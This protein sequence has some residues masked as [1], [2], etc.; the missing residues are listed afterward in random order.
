M[1][2]VAADRGADAVGEHHGFVAFGAE[3]LEYRRVGGTI[4]LG[5]DIGAYHG[6][7]TDLVVVATDDVLLG[8]HV[9]MREQLQH[10]G[11][12]GHGGGDLDR[13]RVGPYADEFLTWDAVVQERH[14]HV[15]HAGVAMANHQALIAGETTEIGHLDVPCI[16]E[17]LERFEVG[18]RHRDDDA[19][20]SLADP[21]L[22]RLQTGVLE[23]HHRQVDLDA[24]ILTHLADRRR[25]PAGATVGDGVVELGV[26]GPLDDLDQ[27]LFGDRVADLYGGAD[28]IDRGGIHTGR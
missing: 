7:A 25:E 28:M 13:S 2:V 3:R 19:L 10:L 16:A 23:R 20:L 22:P 8:G 26:A 12:G 11:G 17:R 9:R 14:R 24:E 18:G 27:A 4:G 1:R 21:D 5:A 6:A 15:D